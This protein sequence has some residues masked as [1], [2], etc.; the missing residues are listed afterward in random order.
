MIGASA[1][2]ASASSGLV[3]I[4][5]TTTATTSTTYCVMNTSP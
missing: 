2:E 1:N 3:Q 5:S 4:S